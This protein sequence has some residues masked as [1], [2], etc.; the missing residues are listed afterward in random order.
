MSRSTNVKRRASAPSLTCYFESLHGAKSRTG[1]RRNSDGVE[2]RMVNDDDD[3]D[4]DDDESEHDTLVG[5]EETSTHPAEFDS[6]IAL[7]PMCVLQS[8]ILGLADFLDWRILT[9]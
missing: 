2:G 8:T 5:S 6:L 9:P 3:D 4:D 7:A 1:H